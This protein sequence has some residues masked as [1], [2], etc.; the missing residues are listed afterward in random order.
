VPSPNNPGEIPTF[1]ILST[2]YPDTT[3][4][5]LWHRTDNAKG[6]QQYFYRTY[7]RQGVN[8]YSSVF[9]SAYYFSDTDTA[10]KATTEKVYVI[11][12]S[13]VIEYSK[14]TIDSNANEVVRLHGLLEKGQ[15]FSAA[16]DFVTANGATVTIDAAVDDYFGATS[17]A[18][19][20]YNDVYHVT[21][22]VSNV[23]STTQPIELEYQTG[24]TLGVYYAKTIGPVYKVAKSPTGDILWSEEVIETRSR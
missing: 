22:T 17:V 5:V 18:G 2:F 6:T 7:V 24:A 13:I 19:I 10:T 1:S 4:S 14:R 20:E 21:Y 3:H 23:T 9:P 16:T 11:L 8:N 12:D 15:S